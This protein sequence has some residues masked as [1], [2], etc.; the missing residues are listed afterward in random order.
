MA[1]K[2]GPARRSGPRGQ[3]EAW[4]SDGTPFGRE[5]TRTLTAHGADSLA[6]RL[7]ISPVEVRVTIYPGGHVAIEVERDGRMVHTWETEEFTG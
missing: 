4:W 3:L 6:A 5:R 2:H 1:R 7:T